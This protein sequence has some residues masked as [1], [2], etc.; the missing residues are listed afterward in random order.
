MPPLLA[1]SRFV[2]FHPVL[3]GKQFSL[4]IVFPVVHVTARGSA[5]VMFE[6]CV[7]PVARTR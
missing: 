7:S 2:T 3:P 5:E 1:C 4:T 6:S